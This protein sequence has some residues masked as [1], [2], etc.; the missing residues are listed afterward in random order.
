MN[1]P[2]DRQLATLAQ[3]CALLAYLLLLLAL[4]ANRWQL[5]LSDWRASVFVW[6]M[7]TL[8]LLL[9]AR[10]MLRGI[11]RSY[12]WLCFLLLIYFA[13]AVTRQFLPQRSALDTILLVLII[14]LFT[15]ALLFI[16]WRARADRIDV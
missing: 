1:T 15:F 3:R 16:R 8:P 6:V 9:F 4:A 12:A 7:Q 10:G 14:A 5:Q 2:T 13:A 11:V